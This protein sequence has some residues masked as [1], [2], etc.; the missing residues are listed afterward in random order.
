MKL[1]L[2]LMDGDEPVF[3]APWEARVFAAV[4]QLHA[5]GRIEWPDFTSAL[6]EA[7]HR[8]NA[9]ASYYGNWLI[10]AERLLDERGL[11]S[12]ADLNAAVR[13]LEA[14]SPRHEHGHD[15]DNDHAH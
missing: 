4:V 15:H 12:A 9:S 7:V 11:L 13:R 14:F 10:A 1:A 6:S 2:P 3:S 8:P 5:T